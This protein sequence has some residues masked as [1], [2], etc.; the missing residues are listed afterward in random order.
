MTGRMGETRA[1]PEGFRP[2]A[3]WLDEAKGVP[4]AAIVNELGLA[5]ERAGKRLVA[6]PACGAEKPAQSHRS[7]GAV[8][9]VDRGTRWWCSSCNERGDGPDLVS[10]VVFGRPLRPGDPELSRD[11][12]GWFGARGWCST[13]GPVERV[14][15]RPA[16]PPER[17]RPLVTEAQLG[18]LWGRCG[19]VTADGPVSAWLRSRGLDPVAIEDRGLARALPEQ[20][21]GWASFWRTLGGR[22]IL[23]VFGQAGELVSLQARTV[24]GAGPKSLAPK[25]SDRSAGVLADGTGRALLRGE[26]WLLESGCRAVFIT[27]GDVDW[28]TRASWVGEAD[29]A[30]PV[31]GVLGADAWPQ[32]LPERIPAGWDVH[33]DVHRDEAGERLLGRVVRALAEKCPIYRISPGVAA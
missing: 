12:R 29:S 10:L 1:R 21:P 25:G 4:L 26:A 32:W 33:V 31:L 18:E 2:R 6:C 11:L 22:C 7:A 19:P 15:L 23:P 13:E 20:P 17:A 9:L 8:V 24:L 14:T 16:P 3:R 27:E 5:W 30:S 28:L